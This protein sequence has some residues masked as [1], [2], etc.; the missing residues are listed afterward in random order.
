[1]TTAF[2]VPLTPAAQVFQIPLAGITYTMTLHWC[3]PV[4]N[5][6]LDIADASNNNIVTGIPL[7]T[8]ADLLG[9]YKYLGIGGSL[10]VQSDYSPYSIPTLANLGQQSHLYFVTVP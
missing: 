5:W 7:I 9:P 6:V 1:M 4:N 10:I 3:K 2:E 8:G